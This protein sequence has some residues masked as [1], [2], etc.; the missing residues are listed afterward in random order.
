MDVTG[1]CVVICINRGFFGRIGSLFKVRNTWARSLS[2]LWTQLAKSIQKR[3]L[4]NSV[5][6]VPTIILLRSK[7]IKCPDLLIGLMDNGVLYQ[8][9]D[10]LMARIWKRRWKDVKD[11]KLLVENVGM[12]KV[13]NLLHITILEGEF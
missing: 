3:T 2:Y 12:K 9:Q 1:I 5:P 7:N 8:Y 10:G 11:G 4:E 6:I 13:V